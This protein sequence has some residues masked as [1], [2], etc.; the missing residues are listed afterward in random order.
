MSDP[1]APGT[2]TAVYAVLGALGL[3]LTGL[4]L[5]VRLCHPVARARPGA[6]DA[7]VVLGA[8]VVTA[9]VALQM[10]NAA[11]GAG[12]SATTSA[13]PTARAV[14][15]HRLDY[16]QIVVEKVAYGA[17]KLSILCF[18]RR[19]FGPWPGFARL[20]AAMIA[21]VA[22]WALAFMLADALIC[23]R[24]PALYWAADQGVTRARC[25]DLAAA[26]LSFAVTDVVT[27]VMILAVPFFYIRKLHM[28][29]RQKLGVSFVFLL[30]F[31]STLGGI[32]RLVFLSV[33]YPLGR[34]SFGYTAPPE[35]D[36]PRILQLINPAFWTIVEMELGL[37]TANLP[38]LAPLFR[39]WRPARSA[40]GRPA[41]SQDSSTRGLAG[42]SA[43]LKGGRVTSAE[44]TSLE[45]MEVDTEMLRSV[46]VG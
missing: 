14:T 5:L 30:G 15:E 45:V 31:I 2:I 25:G 32:L 13:T 8:A 20:N 27:D 43:A 23:G 28:G 24:Q 41:D 18:L 21:A 9:C 10:Y 16:V 22:V 1:Y 39:G 44:M 38:S 34:I 37:Y 3:I 4:R 7:L 36:T 46:S 11:A 17:V 42:G 26:L 12:G 6:D 40:G 29:K 19:L 33:A 35:E